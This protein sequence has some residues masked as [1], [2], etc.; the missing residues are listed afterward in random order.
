[1]TKPR[2][3]ASSAN[4]NSIDGIRLSDGSV[5]FDKLDQTSGLIGA[6]AVSYQSSS[7]SSTARNLN[8][9]LEESVS[10]LD[11][12]ADNTGETNATSHIL[13]ALSTGKP[14]YV[15]PGE[16]LIGSLE[17]PKNAVL[18]GAGIEKTR[19]NV[20]AGQTGMIVHGTTSAIFSDSTQPY[21][22]DFSIYG[23]NYAEAGI[24][25]YA[26]TGGDISN[27]RCRFF[28]NGIKARTVIGLN[29]GGYID[30]SGN[31]IGL[32]VPQLDESGTNALTA[33]LCFN[34]VNFSGTLNVREQYSNAPTLP[35]GASRGIGISLGIA[36]N[37]TFACV[38]GENNYHIAFLR[39]CNMVTFGEVYWEPRPPM[40]PPYNELFV[41][42]VDENGNFTNDPNAPTEG[43]RIENFNTGYKQAR[44]TLVRCKG[45]Y[46]GGDLSESSV[47]VQNTAD[48]A[49][50]SGVE[51]KTATT[52]K[53]PH[54]GSDGDGIVAGLSFWEPVEFT[55]PNIDT[56]KGT[57]FYRVSSD[58]MGYSRR[59][60]KIYEVSSDGNIAF[61]S[62]YGL[63][64]S[65]NAGGRV[66]GTPTS[67]EFSDY[68]EGIWTPTV[69]G[70]VTAGTYELDSSSRGTWTKVGR[71]VTL[72]CYIVFAGSVTGGGVGDLLITGL[73]YIKAAGIDPVGTAFLQNITTAANKIPYLTFGT[74]ATAQTLKIREMQSGGFATALLIG[75]V[76]PGGYIQG[77]ISY[78]V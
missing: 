57:G 31:V 6:Q 4:D 42:G 63:D 10:V 9:K 70:S 52:L 35:Q 51:I 15:P 3:I 17:L 58:V 53:V 36:T 59:G 13:A 37:V 43:I 61:E 18:F 40:A 28:A 16:Y 48:A 44:L 69:R 78:E 33:N 77:T 55:S 24:D 30:L 25:L 56:G 50:I 47:V 8:Q 32:K 72:Q 62:G 23:S 29:F 65:Q 20:V 54:G 2:L 60:V 5:S 73:P 7:P 38:N 34:L 22:K 64:F 45:F 76:T 46:V 12:G 49:N 74:T 39:N 75:S 11:F 67:S 68:E 19:F 71:L 21:L 26:V 14:V 41:V 66:A 1:M 27:V